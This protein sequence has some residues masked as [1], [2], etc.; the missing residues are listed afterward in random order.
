MGMLQETLDK[1]LLR[2]KMKGLTPDGASAVQDS[3]P[4]VRHVKHRAQPSMFEIVRE[5]IRSEA[6]AR[7][8]NAKELDTFAESQD[9]GDDDEDGLPETMY[10]RSDRIARERDEARRIRADRME[11]ARRSAEVDRQMA[12]R[13]RPEEGRPAAARSPARPRTDALPASSAE[14]DEE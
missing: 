14:L 3:K 12:A 8:A 11:E 7:D 4:T 9:F 13:R 2:R 6:L 1:I 10:E 5:Q